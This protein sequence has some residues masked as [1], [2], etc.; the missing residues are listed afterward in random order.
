M[1][2]HRARREFLQQKEAAVVIQA[3]ARGVLGR[4]AQEQAE[5]AA[6]S[7]QARVRGCQCRA[8]VALLVEERMRELGRQ[9]EAATRIQARM[10]G[11]KSRQ[12][13]ELGCARDAAQRIQALVRGVQTRAA[14]LAAMQADAAAIEDLSALLI[15]RVYRGHR[16]RGLWQGLYRERTAA[17]VPVQT[18]YRRHQ[19]SQ[20]YRS[21]QEAAV[22][23]QA[24]IRGVQTRTRMLLALMSTELQLLAE[25]AATCIQSHWRGYLAR[26]RLMQDLQDEL[27]RLDSVQNGEAA[28][29]TTIQA[30]MRG[31]RA[32]REFLQQKE[33]AVVIQACA[34]GVLGRSA[35]EQAELAATSIQA[36]VRSYLLRKSLLLSLEQEV[37]AAVQLLERRTSAATLIQSSTR[38]YLSRQAFGRAKH[39]SVVLQSV[40]RARFVRA[41]KAVIVIQRVWRG[42]LSRSIL[43]GR[44]EAEVFK[45][46]SRQMEIN[47]AATRI[48][49][50]WRGFFSRTRFISNLEV[51]TDREGAELQHLCQ[52][53]SLIQAAVRG[54]MHRIKMNELTSAVLILQAL[55]RGKL[56]RSHLAHMRNAS[57]AATQTIRA[58]LLGLAA[59]NEFADLRQGRKMAH[60]RAAALMRAVVFSNRARSLFLQKHAATITIQR[61]MRRLQAIRET[62]TRESA[63]IVIQSGSRGMLVRRLL[64]L[65]SR[66][67]IETQA[68]IRI[69]ACWRG[70]HCRKTDLAVLESDLED[71]YILWTRRNDAATVIQ[72]CFVGHRS[73]QQLLYKH[74]AA[75]TIQ[76]QIRKLLILR[77]ME[78]GHERQIAATVIQS[79]WRGC[80]GRQRFVHVVADENALRESEFARKWMAASV[81]QAHVHRCKQQRY[82]QRTKASAIFMQAHARGWLFRR[83]RVAA[84]N[85]QRIWRGH[86]GR[87]LFFDAL[88]SALNN[89]E[90]K[91]EKLGVIMQP[92]TLATQDL[93]HGVVDVWQHV[94]EA[95]AQ[96]ARIVR[97]AEEQAARIVQAA[98]AD[99]ETHQFTSKQVPTTAASAAVAAE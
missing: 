5:L 37:L 26:L 58:A 12:A 6:T 27:L 8:A 32:R 21:M 97:A 40:A 73:R 20:Q 35:Q 90:A 95:E 68:A 87:L 77:A 50:S 23:V 71:M 31:H 25:D 86:A 33:A 64:H 54:W 17:V 7:I 91:A 43:C 16:G 39:A 1:R 82:L 24:H 29:A 11:N 44:L 47:V 59:R 89:M 66:E 80:V 81:I 94:L 96:A 99:V 34:R 63:A 88:E 93:D 78:D 14:L 76:A 85:I 75:R 49:S 30:R 46:I 53:S 67:A 69:Q 72:S 18:A 83:G 92:T 28:A 79:M 36:C 19:A 56:A 62:K 55:T 4:S 41:T 48:Q 60:D 38:V 9:N 84:R 51:S 61:H 70:W 57:E 52:A 22:C 2:G 13:H 65:I 3:C 74:M 98:T 42:W 15:Q 45:L 10:R